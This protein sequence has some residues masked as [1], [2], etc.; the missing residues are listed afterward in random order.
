MQKTAETESDDLLFVQDD[1]ETD[2]D[3]KHLLFRLGGEEYG[4]PI[5]RVQTIEEL[6]RIVAVPDM[7]PY[8]RGVI[9][10]R[11][12][13]IPVVDLRA[14]FGM[15]EREYDDRTCII[16][17]EAQERVVG[18][19]VDTVSEVHQIPASSIQPAPDFTTGSGSER[20]VD[21]LGTVDGDV[22]ILLGIDRLMRQE[23]VPEE[24]LQLA[25]AEVDGAIETGARD[26][27]PQ[28]GQGHGS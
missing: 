28:S 18:F 23:A 15:P 1:D 20:F 6:H 21:G 16:I 5:N 2:Q 10:L 8:V 24:L 25:R 11:G 7:P 13:V 9:N 19:I 27:A 17:I 4:V 3:D 22:K 26:G 14:R 12:T